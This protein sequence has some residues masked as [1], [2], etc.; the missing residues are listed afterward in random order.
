M[1]SE[2][3]WQKP[4]VVKEVVVGP[5]DKGEEGT[6]IASDV[7]KVECEDIATPG[8]LRETGYRGTLAFKVLNRG[9]MP[10][11]LAWKPQDRNG[12]PISGHKTKQL[13]VFMVKMGKTG[14]T[15]KKN[16]L[17]RLSFGV[18]IFFFSTFDFIGF[19]YW[20]Q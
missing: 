13:I 19:Y 4:L 7:V 15:P 6:G 18:F 2:P 20:R 5:F 11:W 8:C 10:S 12:S 14:K 1:D 3:P 16:L 17:Y 9:C